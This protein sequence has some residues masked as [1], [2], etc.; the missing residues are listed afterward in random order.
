ILT[1]DGRI[2]FVDLE[3]AE[4]GGDK[5]WDI[6][7]FLC[8]AG[9]YASFSPVKVAETITREFL[10][11]YLEAGGEIRNVKRSLSPRYLKVF[12]FFTP[13]HTLLIIVNTCRK[14]L[15]TKTYNV[16]DNIN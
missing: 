2:F 7:E 1:N 16:A 6:A 9:H 10:S 8:Y 4:R 14:M 5:S 15:E 12:S 13:P 3:Q 11:G